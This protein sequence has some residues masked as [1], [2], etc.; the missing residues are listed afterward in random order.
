[1]DKGNHKPTQEEI[2]DN[3]NYNESTGGLS[4]LTIKDMVCW[5]CK[6]ASK[7]I[8]SCKK[9][10]VKPS[11]AYYTHCIGYIKKKPKMHTPS[12]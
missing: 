3:F 10:E 7:S 5:D 1:M 9:Y 4:S 6:F 11:T 2:N 8:S 12:L